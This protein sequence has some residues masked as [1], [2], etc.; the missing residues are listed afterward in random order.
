MVSIRR[1][2]I[3][4][5]CFIS[6]QAVVAA[7]NALLGGVIRWLASTDA[8]DA[9]FFT[10]QLAVIIVGA[11]I[12]L[13]HWLW[14]LYLARKD[15]I[16]LNAWVR[17]LYL[18]LTKGVFVSYIA[19]AVFNGGG[20]L[21]TLLLPATTG[22]TVPNAELIGTILNSAMT[23]VAT[24]TLWFYH[25]RLTAHAQLTQD[26]VSRTLYQLYMLGFS[27]LGLI[28]AALGFA[29]CQIWVFRWLD[30][31][32]FLDLPPALALVLA[33]GP[34]WAFHEGTRA[35][36]AQL[37]D[38]AAAVLRWGY[39]TLF[40]GTAG[41][42]M[43]IGLAG[44][45]IWLFRKIA[46][47]P[48]PTL[49][50]ALALV[51][52]GLP[53]L[54][55]HELALRRVMTEAVKPI[56]WLYGLGFS[57]VG[58]ASAM[59]GLFIA[60]QWLFAWVGGFHPAVPEGAALLVPGLL[61]WG[62]HQ[63]VMQQMGAALGLAEESSAGFR[64]TGRFLRRLY[65]FAF[66]GAGISLTT[67]GLIGL[68][69]WVFAQFSTQGVFQLADAL[70]LLIV[71]IVVWLYYWRWAGQLFASHL[72][73]ERKSDLRKA[74]LYL[75]IYIAV[76]TAI[77]TVALLVNGTLRALLGLP[78]SGGL[79]LPLSIITASVALWG[80]HA[81]ILR[82]DIAQAG[83][84]ALQAGMQRL[85]WYLVAALGLGAFILGLAGELSV[86]IRWFALGL[87]A[88]EAL[89]EQFAN[90]TAALVAGLPVWLLAWIPAQQA[91]TQ[92]TPVGVA[93]RRSVLRKLYLYFYA[94]VAVVVTLI[95]AITFV[96]QLL[97]ALV[98]LFGGGNLLADIAQSVG[99]TVIATLVWVYHGW[100]LRGDG[101]HAQQ[102]KEAAAQKQ[103]QEKETALAKL[104]TVWE[105]YR[106]AVV[107][108][109]DGTFGRRVLHALKR[110]LPYLALLPIGLTPTA[111]TALEVDASTD[112]AAQLA[113]AQLI[114]APW[115]AIT[116][117]GAVAEC[118]APKIAVPVSKPGVHWVGLS[119]LA[120]S[121]A[122]IVQLVKQLLPKTPKVSSAV[123]PPSEAT[124]PPSEAA[125][126]PNTTEPDPSEH[127]A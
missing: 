80:Y 100:V 87:N 47:D 121:D 32:T 26:A 59:S 122:Q 69:E 6:L 101:Q 31:D 74:Y 81:L 63:W 67:L 94:L 48:T 127:A 92:A 103:A 23:V 15:P 17:T 79:G 34:L 86:V 9:F 49:P 115:S 125:T 62:Y 55:Y 22:S 60:L 91:A 73:D 93:S 83:E 29:L 4:L 27:G 98:G 53:L 44:I 88:D 41:V 46:G 97:N 5:V 28:L 13:G 61:A 71:G 43:L 21:F 50:D 107:D 85:Y 65:V 106:L 118:P 114:V 84:S 66:S 12:F 54:L 124:A 36:K 112:V 51:T 116:P 52:T 24:G 33:G 14:A 82:N 58:M 96:Y 39:A 18:Y 102:D 8:P 108:D 99:F 25:E 1:F 75:I 68:Q 117:G 38:A 10:F 90:F 104:A 19:V 40:S 16:E 57:V 30:G 72:T 105:N 2:Y 77:F 109:G 126:P 64:E 95:T 42:L 3:Y 20:A 37:Q 45:Q 119:A 11:P 76:N 89:K 123:A 70:A 7:L 56:R 35:R 113:T 111:A 110:E 120:E 78:T